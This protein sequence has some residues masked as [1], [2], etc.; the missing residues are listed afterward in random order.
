MAMKNGNDI[1]IAYRGSNEA[2]DYIEV[3][4]PTYLY[5][6]NQQYADAQGV[7]SDVMITYLK[8]N[9]HVTGHSLGGNLAYIGGSLA[10][11]ID[12]AIGTNRLKELVVFN[13]FGVPGKRLSSASGMS[14]LYQG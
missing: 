6:Y 9:L 12:Q 10:L 2:L 11:N 14:D 7:M 13:G 3:N 1:I 4:I 8:A 5:T